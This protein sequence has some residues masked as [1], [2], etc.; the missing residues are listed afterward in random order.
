MIPIWIFG[1]P[2]QY[3]P[4]MKQKNAMQRT[5]YAHFEALDHTILKSRAQGF[6]FWG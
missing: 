3:E 1:F 5:G 6:G 4:S 2:L